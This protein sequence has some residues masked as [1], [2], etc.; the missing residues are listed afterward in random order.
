MKKTMFLAAMF[1]LMFVVADRALAQKVDTKD[2]VKKV[3]VDATKKAVDTGLKLEVGDRVEVTEVSGKVYMNRPQKP[4]NATG[5]EGWT[6][7]KPSDKFQFANATPSSL[8]GYIGDP[9][10]HYQVRKS[11][12]VEVKAAGNLFFAVNDQPSSYGDNSGEFV[13][14][15][16]IIKK[17]F[18]RSK[19]LGG[20]LDIKWVNKT[21]VPITVNWIDQKGKEM[22]SSN[23]I[24][25]PEKIF[26]GSTHVGHIFRVRD[27]KGVEI[28]LIEVE[29][30][31]KEVNIQK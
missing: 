8:V 22:P 13:V 15:Y 16:K 25:Q 27:A 20:K 23:G 9:K 17:D 6:Q 30:T 24:I 1:S 2:E 21:G 29:A 4:E 12:Y 3:T 28:C 10:S 7:F 26:D 14:S 31:S 5:I 11:Q 19:D 18:I